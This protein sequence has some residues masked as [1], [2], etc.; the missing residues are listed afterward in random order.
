L[1][2]SDP[3]YRTWLEPWLKRLNSALKS[4]GVPQVL[5]EL[6]DAYDEMG[7]GSRYYNI[8]QARNEATRQLAGAGR[9]EEALEVLRSNFPLHAQDFECPNREG[10]LLGLEGR[11]M[12]LAA[13]PEAEARLE[14]AIASA[15]RWLGLI[16]AGSQPRPSHPSS[17]TNRP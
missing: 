16:E 15:E 6:T 12:L 2:K 3:D 13:Q 9:Y 8:K 1:D 14:Q 7:H 17:P 11:L 4:G 5:S 10:I